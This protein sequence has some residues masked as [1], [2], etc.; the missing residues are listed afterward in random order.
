MFKRE[1]EADPPIY[2]VHFK[3]HY[4]VRVGDAVYIKVDGRTH[5]MTYGQDQHGDIW[6][7]VLTFSPIWMSQYVRYRYSYFV[8]KFDCEE[9][10]TKTICYENS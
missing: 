4:K 9:N 2:P 5:R 8:A 10:I 7:I 6:T 3:L 1:Y